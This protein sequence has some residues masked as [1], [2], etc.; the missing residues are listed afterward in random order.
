MNKWFNAIGLACIG[1]FLIMAS[2][3][4]VEEKVQAA[5]DARLS[6]PDIRH[7]YDLQNKQDK[8][9]LIQLLKS[10]NPSSRY[11]A[12]RAFA[13]FRDSSALPALFPLLNDPQ[14]QIRLMA[15]FAIGQ[16]GSGT[17]EGPLTAAFDGRDS[18]RLTN[19]PMALSWKPWEK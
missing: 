1:W 4:P 5:F 6:S 19:N 12:A 11:A 18:A 8:D 3:V 13:S 10:E 2:C 14:Q 9:S 17:A 7:V 15:A 16:I